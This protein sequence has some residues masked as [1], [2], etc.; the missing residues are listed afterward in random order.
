MDQKT[1]GWLTLSGKKYYFD[2]E[3]KMVTGTVNIDGKD[4]TFNESGEL[5]TGTTEKSGWVQ[6][7]KKMGITMIITKK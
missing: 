3:G 6:S 5:T 2:K 4:Y 7:G 1:T